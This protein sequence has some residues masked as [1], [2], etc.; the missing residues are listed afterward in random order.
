MS[1]TRSEAMWR[2]LSNPFNVLDKSDIITSH[3]SG[4][5]ADIT[6][7]ITGGQSAIVLA[8]ASGIGKSALIHYL[9]RLPDSEWS[10]RDELID[11]S[12][13]LKLDDMNFVQVD[14]RPLE[15][16]EQKDKFLSTFVEQCAIALHRRYIQDKQPASVELDLKGL[17]ELLRT[18]SR[19][20]LRARYFLMLDSIERL[21]WL[22][23][24]SFPLEESTAETEQ[25]RGIALLDHCGAIRTLVDLIDEF[26]TFG[27]ILSIESLPRPKIA[28]QFKH[29]SADLARFN[30]MTLQTFT[31]EDTTKFL[32]QVGGDYIFSRSEQ[33][34]L[35]KQAGTHPYLIQQFCFYTFHLK[36]Q[37]ASINGAWTEL[38]EEHKDQLIERISELLNTF[39]AS[40]WKRLHE[41]IDKG[42]PET[43]NKFYEF[44]NL[45]AQKQAEDV[46]DRTFWDYL[47]AEL[48]YILYSE[49]ILRYDLFR[50]IHF[51]GST[52]SRYLAQKAYEGNEQPLATITASGRILIVKQPENPQVQISVSELE[53]RL[54]KTLLQHPNRCTEEEL[55]MG[56][57][58]KKIDR[59]VFAQRIHQLRKKLKGTRETD[60]IENRYGGIYTLNNADWLY[61]D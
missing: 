24:P 49:G 20:T 13:Q 55:I 31:W 40:I 58:G 10:W 22:N 16:I 7:I 17:R 4:R 48:R 56:A 28:D 3:V 47:G 44:I 60:F 34:W 14:L 54:L 19:E 33:E 42:R 39:L 25:E 52:L 15:G 5:S 11:L 29:V 21:G 18:I 53:Y 2:T 59:S 36:Q 1:E 41:A 43:K 46:I 12:D 61:L 37:F 9:Q 51:P 35:R 32:A 6:E 50:P 8:G 30:T 23:L 26:R 27:V 45:L 38:Q 57:W